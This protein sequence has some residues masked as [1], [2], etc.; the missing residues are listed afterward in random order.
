MTPY[1]KGFH[2]TIEIWQGGQDS[3]GW[4]VKDSSSLGYNKSITSLDATR[5]GRHGLD[6]SLAASYLAD[7]AEDEDM[8]GAN[9]RVRARMGKDQV[10]VPGDGL[11]HPV[12]R[13]KDDLEVLTWLT[14]P[15]LP[16]L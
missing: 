4:K 14:E 11:T 13:F 12:P 7:K 1:L 10:Y 3:D 16:P 9:H 6:L 15:E 2:L 5:A 8:A